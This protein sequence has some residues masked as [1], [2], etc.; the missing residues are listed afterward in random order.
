MFDNDPFSR[1]V[2]VDEIDYIY[3]LPAGAN[4]TLTLT[5]RYSPQSKYD[6]QLLTGNSLWIVCII[7]LWEV[8]NVKLSSQCSFLILHQRCCISHQ[9]HDIVRFRSSYV[10]I[11]GKV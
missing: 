9:V 6:E 8:F 10:N 5:G 11:F 3:D 7:Y 4:E 1:M 2:L